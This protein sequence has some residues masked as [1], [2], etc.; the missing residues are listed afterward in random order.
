MTNERDHK[1]THRVKYENNVAP[2]TTD[3]ILQRVMTE[4]SFVDTDLFSLAGSY[5]QF[6]I[7]GINV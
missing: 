6:Y 7:C 5:F 3:N 4:P 2:P 1:N